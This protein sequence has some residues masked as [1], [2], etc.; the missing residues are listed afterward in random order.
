MTVT[1]RTRKAIADTDWMD[2][3]PWVEPLDK[4]FH[5]LDSAPWPVWL[6][7]DTL[8]HCPSVCDCPVDGCSASIC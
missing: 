3:E 7:C 2:S 5:N 4:H 8:T 6:D 1:E